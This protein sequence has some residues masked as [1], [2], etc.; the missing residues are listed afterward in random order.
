MKDNRITT[1][2]SPQRYPEPYQGT[3]VDN[4]ILWERSTEEGL[5]LI[6]WQ[7]IGGEL[8]TEHVK[9]RSDMITREIGVFRR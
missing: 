6:R 7:L 4:Y 3:R 1:R 9:V 8:H 5:E 2:F